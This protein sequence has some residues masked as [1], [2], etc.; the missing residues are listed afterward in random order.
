MKAGPWTDRSCGCAERREEGVG[1]RYLYRLCTFKTN[2][3]KSPRGFSAGGRGCG[4]ET[5][6][7]GRRS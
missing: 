5:V 2:T 3:A 6:E 7:R 4:G 1:V